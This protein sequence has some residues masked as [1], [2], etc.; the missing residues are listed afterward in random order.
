MVALLPVNLADE[1]KQFARASRAPNTLLAYRSDAKIFAAWCQSRGYDALPSAPGIICGFLAD[2]ARTC[3]AATVGRRLAAI[4]HLHKAA[5][6]PSPIDDSVHAVMAGIRR[7]LGT[8]P[9]PRAPL[10]ADA[11]KQIID[12]M[13][14]DPRAIRDRAMILLGWSGALR[15]SELATLEVA[16]ISETADGLLITIR[17]SKGDKD[18]HGQQI[19]IT[20]ATQSRYNAADALKAWLD[21][22]GK[23]EGR[24]FELS[25][26]GISLIVQR[27]ARAVG[28]TAQIAAHSLRSGA[29]TTAA[30]NGASIPKMLELSRHRDVKTLQQYWH[31]TAIFKDHAL[32]GAL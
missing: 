11:I 1:V 27:R 22:S 16:D 4:V 8:A 24:I 6:L 19:A 18:S 12:A 23:R 5:G 25:P 28:I 17:H 14:E 20:K 26:Y 30:Q 3:S 32:K 9:K 7:T 29:L 10:V 15:R 21:A 31:K 13:A 2:Q